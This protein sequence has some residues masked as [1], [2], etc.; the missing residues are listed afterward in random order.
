MHWISRIGMMGF[1]A[2]RSQ[3]VNIFLR[4]VELIWTKYHWIAPLEG[5]VIIAAIQTQLHLIVDRMNRC[6]SKHRMSNDDY[7][8]WVGWGCLSNHPS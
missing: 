2:I 1:T 6:A 7:Y 5:E 3:S 8:Y 4:R